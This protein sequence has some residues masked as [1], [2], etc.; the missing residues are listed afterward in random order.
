MTL[1]GDRPCSHHSVGSTIRGFEVVRSVRQGGYDS[2]WKLWVVWDQKGTIS[3]ESIVVDDLFQFT[4]I[5]HGTETSSLLYEWQGAQHNTEV[6]TFDPAYFDNLLSLDP[7][8]PTAPL[9]NAD[10]S[11]TFAEHL[12]YPGRFSVLSLTTAL[13]EY[14]AQLPRNKAYAETSQSFPSLARK[15][16][17]IVGCDLIMGTNP[18]TGA[19]EVHD[20]RSKLKLQW[21]GIWARVR[22][23]DLSARWPIG[24]TLLDDQ[25]LFV[26]TREGCSTT[27]AQ[28]TCA[29]IN[30]L[31][32]SDETEGLV[33]LPN[34][35]LHSHPALESPST[36]WNAI[37]ISPAGR[38]I[39]EVLSG[40]AH[41]EQ[42]GSALEAFV[43]N[44]NGIVARGL[45]E[46][47]EVAAD[48]LWNDNIV[49]YLGEEDLLAVRRTLSDSNDLSTGLQEVLDALA[50]VEAELVG[51]SDENLRFSGIGNAFLAED[52]ATTIRARYILSRNVLLVALFA[53]ASYWLPEGATENEFWASPDTEEGASA[54]RLLSQAFTTYQRYRVLNF[55]SEQPADES[56]TRKGRK[57]LKRRHGEDGLSEGFGTLRVQG[58][59]DGVD[60]DDHETAYSLLHS[61]LARGLAQSVHESV[62]GEVG[63]ARTTLLESILALYPGIWDI[64][65]LQKDTQLAFDVLQDGHPTHA[66]MITTFY[67]HSPGMS[68]VKAR[69][70]LDIGEIDEAVNYFERAASGCKSEPSRHIR[71][72]RANARWILGILD[73]KLEWDSRV[74]RILPACHSII[75]GKRCR[76]T[77]C[78]IREP[79]SAIDD[80]E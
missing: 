17:R 47:V 48:R 4:T 60:M 68:Y 43:D 15:Y 16:E 37:A 29:F 25:Q 73:T 65:P 58:E 10:I 34:T 55:V 62:L 72:L 71:P 36:R 11:S 59:D 28:D 23:L 45:T 40:V 20:F 35:A 19:A 54:I 1:A 78:S 56:K 21:L 39:A 6:E 50:T 44:M 5:P 79:R 12:F 76:A 63:A 49:T 75:R 38:H 46:D 41:D 53:V 30:D 7:P 67:P 42:N 64:T 57:S 18:S 3:C 14:I 77:N 69:A 66:G 13:D 9:E 22:N 24:T 61:L 74:D 27:V 26:V 32:S 51:A 31:G 70:Y 80:D 52:V 2:G 33:T 8:D